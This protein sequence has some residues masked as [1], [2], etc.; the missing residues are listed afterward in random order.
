MHIYIGVYPLFFNLLLD[1]DELPLYHGVNNKWV[2]QLRQPLCK[3]AL[4]D[5][6]SGL[7]YSAEN[8]MSL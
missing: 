3:M 5:R 8:E 2:A 1:N 7:L 6:T 4:D